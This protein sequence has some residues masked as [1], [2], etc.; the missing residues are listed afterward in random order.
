MIDSNMKDTASVLAANGGVIGLS[1]SECNEILLFVSTSLAIIFTLYK[2]Y[3]LS[4][5]K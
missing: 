1:F 5:K 4:K 2:F 3:K